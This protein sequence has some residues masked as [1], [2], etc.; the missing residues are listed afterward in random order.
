VNWRYWIRH[1][2]RLLARVR[3]WLWERRNQDKPWLTPGA[4]EFLDATLTRDMTAL[5]FGSG[6]STAWY[7]RK[8]GRLISVEHAAG[9]F[10]QVSNDLARRKC[11]NVDYRHVPLNHPE[12]EPEH[13]SYD[14]LPD[15]VAVAA[16]LSDGSLDLVVVDGHYRTAC[17]AAVLPK[18]KPGGLLLVDDANMWPGNS[19]PVPAD[20]P[21]VSRTTNGLKS[22]LVWRKPVPPDAPRSRP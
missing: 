2:G 17:I 8:V 14:P 4:V 22:T 11:D 13:P 1:P 6:R 15:Y 9:W 12:S 7:S 10:E 21:E 5:E 16:S 20:W 3:Y 19:P 18:L